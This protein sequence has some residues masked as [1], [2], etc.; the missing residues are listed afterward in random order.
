[1][2]RWSFVAAMLGSTLA[3]SATANAEDHAQPDSVWVG[4]MK[5]LNTIDGKPQVNTY[6]CRLAI[7][8]RDGAKFTG[9]YWWAN[10]ARGIGIEGI[11]EK[12]GM[13]FTA[14][15]ELKGEGVNDLINNVRI[16]GR[17]RGKGM[18]E[19]QLKYVVPGTQ[20]RSGE[21]VVKLKE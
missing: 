16:S 19:L 17:F 10:D 3:I 14:T 12:G 9:E 15:K 11:V 2:F 20:A 1:M 4:S 13:R 7:L 8:K 18:K 21:I 5:T 6:D